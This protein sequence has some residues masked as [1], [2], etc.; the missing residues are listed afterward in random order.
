MNSLDSLEGNYHRVI[1]NEPP[2]EWQY[3]SFML[4]L[5]G[6]DRSFRC[7]CGCNCFHQYDDEP[8]RY[9]CNSCET[10]YKGE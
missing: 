8:N 10:V 2:F 1:M 4:K 5:P 3:K 7:G 6:E 9:Y